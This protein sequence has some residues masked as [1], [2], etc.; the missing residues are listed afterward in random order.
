MLLISAFMFCELNIPA[1]VQW[2]NLFTT[3]YNVTNAE[4]MIYFLSNE[5]PCIYSVIIVFTI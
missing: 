3:G 2:I 4:C 5:S 1:A